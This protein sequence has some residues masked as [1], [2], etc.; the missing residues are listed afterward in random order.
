MKKNFKR[1]RSAALLALLVLFAASPAP[2]HAQEATSTPETATSTPETPHLTIEGSVDVPA[3]CE[4]IDAD[5]VSHTYPSASS[6]SYLAICALAAASDDGLISDI[7]LSNQFPDFGLFV[8]SIN[9]VAADPSSEF[10]ALYKNGEF[11]SAGLT[12]LPVSVGDTIRLERQ[13]FFGANLGDY[14]DLRVG[15]LLSTT[16]PA[17]STPSENTGGGG[18]GGNSEER[19]FDVP[20][21]LAYLV[22]QQESDGSFD[23][24]FLSDWAAI[25]FAAAGNISAKTALRNYL[26]SAAP[27]LSSVTDYE[28]H[29]MALLALG[30]NPY[31]GTSKDYL[32]PIV[33]AF[34]GAQIGDP[35]LDN[36]DIFAL[37]P[38]LHA[39]Y[40]SDDTI[41][42]RTTEFILSRQQ[43][44]GA[45]DGSVDVTAAAIQAL[46]LVDD[47][48][49]VPPALEKAQAYLRGAQGAD[50]GFGNSFST[51][52]VLQA[53]AA[54][55]DSPR[56]W[57]KSG[58]SPAEY[59]AERQ[60]EDGGV[61]PSSSTRQMR[62]WATMY[63]IPA[64]LGRPWDA[65]LHSFPKQESQSEEGSSSRLPAVLGTATSTLSV[66]TT[67]PAIATTTPIIAAPSIA[68]AKAPPLPL[69]NEIPIATLVATASPEAADVVKEKASS[70]G[71]F[72]RLWDVIVSFFTFL[73]RLL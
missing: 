66:T 3:Q 9:D 30:I 63:A 55:G 59:L 7:G 32:T 13:D 69:K 34:D 43:G 25:A 71:F 41:I 29:A 52:W 45:W 51:S 27:N 33:E 37:F 35:D 21:A 11:A 24:E 65:L 53:I 10:W 62:Q 16:S 6:E 49:G 17:T 5:G 1:I 18:G 44:S 22:D 67:T 60:E 4:V 40:D 57:E 73:S 15:S 42:A 2:V 61:E 28:R 8:T 47:L 58:R 56:E 20:A 26:L 70:G 23:S 50:G 36:D 72:S 39:G 46:T 38:L 54:L 19:E 14:L 68:I 12:S 48:P 31:N 64:T